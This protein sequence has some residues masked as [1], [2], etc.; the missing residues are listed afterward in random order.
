L[1][2][3]VH[4]YI[5]TE[6][7]G[8]P[9]KL[10]RLGAFLPD[11]SF[12][13]GLNRDEAHLMG[14]DFL[15]WSRE[16]CPEAHDVALAVLSHGLRPHG[17]DYYADEFWPGQSKGWCFYKGA[18]WMDRVEAATHLPAQLIYWKS[19]NFVEM[20]CELITVA[21]HPGI[22][23]AVVEALEDQQAVAQL[24]DI[25]EQYQE[26][27]AFRPIRSYNRALEIFALREVTAAELAR[28]QA[29][30]F[31]RRH[32]CTDADI[33]AMTELLLE[34]QAALTDDYHAF[35]AEVLP[36]LRATIDKAIL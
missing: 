26:I 28:T 15:A 7:F 14:R 25:I 3:I 6:L 35:L 11:L 36:K 32:N 34:M 19:H 17:I 5:N 4:H 27:P 23:D 9:S 31:A 21:D 16:E 33:P 30:S 8:T 12:G 22:N 1:F 13:F 29:D 10:M 18:A 2:P 24:A 20:A